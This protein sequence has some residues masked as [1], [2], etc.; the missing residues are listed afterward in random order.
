MAKNLINFVQHHIQNTSCGDPVVGSLTWGTSYPDIC[1]TG[2]KPLDTFYNPLER[3]IEKMFER[4]WDFK[5]LPYI[6][7]DSKLPKTNVIE[8]QDSLVFECF[9]PF[10]KKE[11][12]K[13]TLD[14]LT[15]VIKIEVEAHQE[16]ENESTIYHLRE[17]SRSSFKRSFAIDKR[18][19][20]KNATGDFRDGILKIEIPV[21]K[22]AKSIT[23][24]L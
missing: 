22:D 11:D 17:I 20:M 21:E 1:Y 12:I 4:A 9:I 3:K 13:I 23:L 8:K 6:S 2:S 5:S 7:D 15:N 14:P 24:T 18:Y 16:T 19:N 10:A